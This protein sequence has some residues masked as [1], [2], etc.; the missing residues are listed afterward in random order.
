[1]PVVTHYS[2]LRQVWRNAQQIQIQLDISFW[3][4]SGDKIYLKNLIHQIQLS[5]RELLEPGLLWPL[6]RMKKSRNNMN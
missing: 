3:A 6:E 2:E 1:M 4:D 5:S